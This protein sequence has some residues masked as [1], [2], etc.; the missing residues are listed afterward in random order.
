MDLAIRF[1]VLLPILVGCIHLLLTAMGE[2][3][4]QTGWAYIPPGVALDPSP[5]PIAEHLAIWLSSPAYVVTLALILA[6]RLPVE[7]TTIL[8]M[9]TPFVLALWYFIGRWVDIRR[10]KAV[11]KPLRL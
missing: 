8:L 10:S 7:G 3:Q 4:R 6:I 11:V 2:V 9:E 5:L 1:R